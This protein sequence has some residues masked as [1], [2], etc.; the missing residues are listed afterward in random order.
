MHVE[1]PGCSDADRGGESVSGG[2]LHLSIDNPT[3]AWARAEC[4][5]TF[6]RFRV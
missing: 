5:T 6:T 4:C 2:P 1:V 3:I